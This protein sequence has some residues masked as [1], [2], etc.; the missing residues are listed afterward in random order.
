MPTNA[1][2]QLEGTLTKNLKLHISA[3]TIRTFEN[4]HKTKVLSQLSVKLHTEARCNLRTTPV[5]GFKPHPN[6]KGDI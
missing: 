6:M 3:G 1:K 2:A 5:Y 4:V